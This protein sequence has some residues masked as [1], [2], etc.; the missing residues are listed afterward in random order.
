M[1]ER[2]LKESLQQVSRSSKNTREIAELY[3]LSLAFYYAGQ[4]EKAREGLLEVLK[5]ESIPPA[6]AKTIKDDLIGI[7][8][9]LAISGRKSEIAELYYRSMAF[10]HAGQFEKA[11]DG[12]VK[13]LKSDL[14]PVP[15]I[16]TIRDC[17]TNIDNT[18][19]PGVKPPL[20]EK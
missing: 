8:N 20:S 13:V 16:I 9:D 3:Y 18:L 7:D 10:Y 17:L 5:S 11:K 6:V 14:V 19:S 2:N 1:V 12:L 4:L 15:M